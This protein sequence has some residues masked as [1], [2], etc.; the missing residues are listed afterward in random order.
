MLWTTTPQ[1]FIA[2]GFFIG[3]DKNVENLVICKS[4]IIQSVPDFCEA[5]SILKSLA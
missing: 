3:V 4:R 5:D 2:L 1:S